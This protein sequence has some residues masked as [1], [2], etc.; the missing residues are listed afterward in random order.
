[1]NECVGKTHQRHKQTDGVPTDDLLRH[2]RALR[3][4]VPQENSKTCDCV[5]VYQNKHEIRV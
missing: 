1:M 2:N 3:S 5:A 4:I